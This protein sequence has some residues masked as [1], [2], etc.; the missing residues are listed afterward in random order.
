M[1]A[2][3][4]LTLHDKGIG[5]LLGIEFIDV[6]P[7]RVVA[8][9]KLE[10]CHFTRPDVVHGGFIMALADAAGAYGAVMNLPDGYTTATVDSST[11]FLRK[12]SGDKLRCVS[13]PVHVGNTLSVWRNEVYRGK[14][15]RPIAEVTQSQLVIPERSTESAAT[16]ELRREM[17][18]STTHEDNAD[19]MSSAFGRTAKSSRF[20]QSVVDDRRQQIFEGASE[21][22][23]EKGFAK[24]TIREISARAGLPVP[25][26]Y[27]YVKRKEDLLY[28]I[29][30]YFMTDIVNGLK[31]WRKSEAP[32]S[33]RLD[34]AIRTM[35]ERFDRNQRYIK[36]MFQET[37]A[38]TPES[39]EKVYE[40]DGHYIAVIRGLLDNLVEEGEIQVENTDLLANMIYFLCVIW[41]LR[42]W[43][44]G[45]YGVELVA[46]EIVGF[47]L[48][49]IGQKHPV[50]ADRTVD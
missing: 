17:M 35:I 25:T 13:T 23:A 36:I 11:R 48:R 3:T 40:L 16:E 14:D 6:E 18:A 10:S 38:L 15:D 46:D 34:G 37:R 39:R 4:F 21:V 47:V 49:G 50:A 26:M 24:A 28:G 27:Q 9:M 45:K 19:S 33:V 30:E 8:V 31:E 12:G 1:D 22:I 2:E 44:I 5:N 29:Y 20:S 32:G 42:H 43:S 41:P 7:D